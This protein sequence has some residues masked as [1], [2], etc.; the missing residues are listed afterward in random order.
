[1]TKLSWRKS[2]FSGSQANCVEVADHL[3]AVLVRDTKDRTGPVL[4]LSDATWRDLTTRIKMGSRLILAIPG[5]MLR[6]ASPRAERS[7]QLCIYIFYGPSVAWQLAGT[8]P[9]PESTPL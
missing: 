4:R 2:T 8:G 3:N 5:H 6:G 1:M 7:P 9:E